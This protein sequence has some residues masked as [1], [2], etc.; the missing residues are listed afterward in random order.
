M[1]RR[2]PAP[3]AASMVDVRIASLRQKLEHDPARPSRIV[4]VHG[5]GCKLVG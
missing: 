5:V 3:A 1:L 2:R 4:T